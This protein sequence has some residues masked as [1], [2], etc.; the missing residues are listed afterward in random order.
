MI[1]ATPHMNPW[2]QVLPLWGLF[3]ILTLT[4]ILRHELWLDEAQHF[5]IARDSGSLP[6]LFRNMRYD[7][8]VQLWNYLLF[9]IVHYISADP[10]AMQLLHLLIINAAV[11]LFLRFAPF[12]LMVK[13]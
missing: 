12:S 1:S 11:L 7:G 6:E 10:L 2:K 13:G 9:F 4:G 8:H 5:L 3:F